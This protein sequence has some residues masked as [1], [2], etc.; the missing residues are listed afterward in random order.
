[1]VKSVRGNT[2]RWSADFDTEGN[3]SAFLEFEDGTPAQ[4]SNNGYGYFDIA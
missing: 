3:Y 4:V 2:G 1:M